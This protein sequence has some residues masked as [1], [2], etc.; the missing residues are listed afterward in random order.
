MIRKYATESTDSYYNAVAGSHGDALRVSLSAP[1]DCVA[2]LGKG[3]SHCRRVA[4]CHER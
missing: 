1:M 4:P 3:I 2:T